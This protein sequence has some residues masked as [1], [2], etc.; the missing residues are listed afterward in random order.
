MKK[1]FED[2]PELCTVNDVARLF[3]V[4]RRTV[5]RWMEVVPGFPIPVTPV[6]SPI[7]FI[8]SEITDFFNHRAGRK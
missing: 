4:D 3:G 1:H 6:G 8:K 5:I 7:K 2:A